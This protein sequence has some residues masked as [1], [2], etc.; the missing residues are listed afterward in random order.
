MHGL[1]NYPNQC[2]LI[3]TI[4]VLEHLTDDQIN[5]YLENIEAKYLLLSS[6]PYTTTPERD[7][8]WGHINIKSVDEWIE[9][10]ADYGY[11]LEKRLTIPTDWT[12]L[13]KK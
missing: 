7:A 12:L 3:V 5:E 2:D 10:V 8:L 4:E 13:F 1:D 11:S 9:F 6:T